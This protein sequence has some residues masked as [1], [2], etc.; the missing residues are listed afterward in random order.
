M[1]KSPYYLDPD[2]WLQNAE[3]KIS[4]SSQS[5]VLVLSWSEVISQINRQVQNLKEIDTKPQK[6][7]LR[8]IENVS[9]NKSQYLRKKKDNYFKGDAA[10]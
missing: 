4:S 10:Q 3:R 1:D 2:N 8:T 9:I 5:P 6:K 7:N